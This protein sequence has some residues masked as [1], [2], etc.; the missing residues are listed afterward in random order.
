MRKE[1]ERVK[2][3]TRDKSILPVSYDLENVITL[4]KAEVGSFFYKRKLNLYNLTPMTSKKQG[5]CSI[6]TEVMSRRS[7]D[8]IASAFIA[9][10]KKIIA[11][12][13]LAKHTIF[14]SDSRVPQ[15]R[16]SH[17]SQAI[18]QF[19]CHQDAIKTITMKYSL[20]CHSCVHDVDNI[21][22]QIET[23]MSTSEFFSLVSFLCMLLLVSRSKPYRCIQMH[24]NDFKDYSA[25][26]KLL[27]YSKVPY[28]KVYVLYPV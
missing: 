24:D 18:I 21:H 3:S 8:D 16:N 12:N 26:S 9:L 1:K 14:W 13:P 28:I 25:A 4:P 27:L 17:I 5:Y 23:V 15:N 22:K 10:L 6:S 19:L 7:G 2:I 20:A 11:D